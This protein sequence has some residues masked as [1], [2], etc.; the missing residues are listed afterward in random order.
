MAGDDHQTR[1][2]VLKLSGGA[3]A[4]F[5]A[6]GVVNADHTHPELTTGNATDVISWRA[7][8]HGTLDDL[9]AA[10]SVDV[11]FE[12][13]DPWGSGTTTTGTQNMTDTGSFQDT[14]ILQSNT[15]YAYRACGIGH[16]GVV[17]CG[18]WEYVHTEEGISPESEPITTGQS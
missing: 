16:E 4:S 12:Y 18:S 17:E 15:T 5:G 9:G 2:N 1:R 11:Y 10:S 8:L 14:V 13:D 7:T 6:M 3:L